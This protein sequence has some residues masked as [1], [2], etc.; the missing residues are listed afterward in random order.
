MM[1]RY[2]R[3]IYHFRNKSLTDGLYNVYTVQGQERLLVCHLDDK[4]IEY[5]LHLYLN[6]TS[7]YFQDQVYGHV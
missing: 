7:S 5:L 4:V 1:T 3:L 6:L 2:F